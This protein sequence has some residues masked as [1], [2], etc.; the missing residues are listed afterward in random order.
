VRFAAN[1]VLG[2]AV[3]FATAALTT[4][5]AAAGVLSVR[6]VDT[7]GTAV[8]GANVRIESAESALGRLT[9]KAGDASLEVHEGGTLVVRAFGFEEWRGSYQHAD[10]SALFRIEL[11]P[12]VHRLPGVEVRG[13]RITRRTDETAVP[14]N[15]LTG[16]SL[17]SLR[18]SMPVLADRLRAVPEVGMLG[19]DEYNSAPAVR[20]LARFRTVVVL[21]G[22]RI[23]SDRE[24]GA[25]AGFVDPATLDVVEVIRGP[26]SV[27]YGSDAIGGVVHMTSATG[28]GPAGPAWIENGYSS[29]NRGVRS[30]GGGAWKLGQVR[31][32]ATGAYARAGDYTL[33]GSGGPWSSDASTARNSGFE[34]TTFR[35]GAGWKELQASTFYSF[36]EDIG[37]PGLESER[38]TVAYDKHTLYSLS[39]GRQERSTVQVSGALH[40]TE[41]QAIVEEPRGTGMRVQKRDYSS[42]DWSATAMASPRLGNASLSIGAQVDARSDVRIVRRREDRDSTGAVTAAGVDQ[43]IGHADAGQAG[44]FAHATVPG[45]RTRWIGGARLDRTWREGPASS[46]GAFVPTGQIG[47]MRDVFAG[48]TLSL[49]LATSYREPTV[50][51]LYFSGKRPA[52]YIE[53]NPSLDAERSFQI[54]LGAAATLGPVGAR[55]STFGMIV[56]DW[57]GLVPL[58]AP[59]TMTFRNVSRA[60]VWGG[61][62]EI[63]PK[64]AWRGLRSR[65]FVDWIHGSHQDGTPLGDMHA[66]RARVELTTAR[67]AAT[68][69]ATWRGA[70][71]HDRVG[72]GERTSPGYSLFETGASV[73]WGSAIFGLAVENLLDHE[74]YERNDPVSYP[75]PGRSFHLTLRFEP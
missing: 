3:A 57:I 12:K 56:S 37:R 29:V 17:Q 49:D 73:R 4:L 10:T 32:G 60:N 70:L 55:I 13:L 61:S 7:S 43:W 52:G 31:F 19:R 6:V 8:E 30:A 44:L 75:S 35:V 47:V 63:Q 53:G 51:E 34:R 62:V 5:P 14:V 26:G 68:A 16:P 71:D 74:V 38:F 59:D 67:G 33:P 28:A 58:A 72:P 27:L 9:S 45:T 69:H 20:G 54:D 65:V 15:R 39:W 50:S 42:L 2:V 24:I 48:T 1:V 18:A 36:G 11:Q 46:G 21:D 25:T 22:A 64:N 40:P 23:H 41:W 66:P